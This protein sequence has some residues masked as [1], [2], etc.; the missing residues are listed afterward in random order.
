MI[1]EAPGHSA[2]GRHANKSPHTCFQLTP[3]VLWRG[4]L[5][6]S[7]R[8]PDVT[9]TFR[10]LAD[11]P[12]NCSGIG[13]KAGRHGGDTSLVRCTKRL[14]RGWEEEEEEEAEAET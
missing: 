4:G 1:R 5:G 7:K 10:S 11:M 2:T 8:L 13:S 9:V 14:P 6:G 3:A 12:L